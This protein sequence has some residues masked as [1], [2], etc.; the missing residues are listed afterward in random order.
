MALTPTTFPD[1]IDVVPKTFTLDGHTWTVEV[2]QKYYDWSFIMAHFP[3]SAARVRALIPT[4]TL[5]PVELLPR[6]AVVTL[7]AFEYRH[8]ATLAPYNEVGIMVPVRY[9][10]TSKIPLLPLLWPDHYDVGFWIHHLPV[11]KEEARAAGVHFWNFPKVVAEITFRD[12]GWMRECELREKGQHVL[13][14]SAPV[15]E[16]RTESRQFYA[17][18]V[19]NGQVLKTL[20]DTRAP[21]YAWNVPGQASFELGDHEVA[22]QLRDL[23]VQNLAIAGLYATSARSRLHPGAVLTTVA[24]PSGPGSSTP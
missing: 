11:T 4:D 2:P 19:M 14:L 9:K 18:S 16:T 10:P 24:P 15:G 1:G 21:Y 8:P 13:T 5:Q 17:F 22:Q 7:A 23:E 20:V 6:V 12:V 3:A